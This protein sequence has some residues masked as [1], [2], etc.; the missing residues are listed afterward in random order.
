MLDIFIKDFI[1][2]LPCICAIFF[3]EVFFLFLNTLCPFTP[4]SFG[5]L[6]ARLQSKSKGSTSGSPESSIKSSSTIPFSAS[7]SIIV[8]LSLAM[9]HFDLS[10]AAEVNI[11]PPFRLYNQTVSLFAI[12]SVSAQAH[13]RY[14]D[15]YLNRAIINN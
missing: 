5:A 3:K 12:S 9:L 1:Q 2:N 4:A 6:K 10:S 11:S 7:V 8:A 13:K 14:L 15:E